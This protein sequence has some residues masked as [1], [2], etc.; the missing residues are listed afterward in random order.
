[1]VLGFSSGSVANICPDC[2][3]LAKTEK[4]SCQISKT[5]EGRFMLLCYS[6]RFG[7]GREE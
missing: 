6:D 7:G 4:N 3:V 5:S 1:M 2:V